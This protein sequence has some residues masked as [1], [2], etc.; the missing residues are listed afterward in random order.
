VRDVNIGVLPTLCWIEYA[1]GRE[2]DAAVLADPD[3]ARAE[4]FAS[5]I[6]ALQNDAAGF[7]KD[8]RSGWPNAVQSLAADGGTPLDA[9][10]TEAAA[11]HDHCV[12]EVERTLDRISRRHGDAAR[13]WVDALAGLLPGFAQ[14][15]LGTPRYSATLPD[16]RKVR[17]TLRGRAPHPR[18]AR[19]VVAA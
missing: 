15:H 3:L 17:L 5:R 11:R 18:G 19:D 6:V 13:F 16:G 8:A 10:F 14:W 1:A 12:A 7:D 4:R 9:A 2:L